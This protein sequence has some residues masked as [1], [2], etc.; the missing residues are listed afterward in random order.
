MSVSCV[1]SLSINSRIVI[2]II[3]ITIAP[4]YLTQSRICVAAS[5]TPTPT[6]TSSSTIIATPPPPPVTEYIE[7]SGLLNVPLPPTPLIPFPA[8][9]PLPPLPP[10]D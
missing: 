6:I 7:L 4:P 8:A 5:A 10:L 1:D 3:T 2:S 9:L